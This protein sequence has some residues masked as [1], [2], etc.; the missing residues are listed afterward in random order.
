VYFQFDNGVYL[1]KLR[2][3]TLTFPTNILLEFYVT[4]HCCALTETIL[5]R[6][7]TRVWYQQ[8]ALSGPAWSPLLHLIKLPSIRIQTLCCHQSNVFLYAKPVPLLKTYTVTPTATLLA[9]MSG[10]ESFTG[11]CKESKTGKTKRLFVWVTLGKQRKSRLRQ[12]KQEIHVRRIIRRP[13]LWN[14]T[15]FASDENT[16]ILTLHG[17]PCSW[18]AFSDTA[19][20]IKAKEIKLLR[21]KSQNK[22]LNSALFLL[23][24]H[25]IKLKTL[26]QFRQS[27]K[28]TRSFNNRYGDNK[29]RNN[30]M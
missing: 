26:K 3:A 20:A 9:E 12:K 14:S 4:E 19:E 6:G 16:T 25:A 1:Q 18:H 21:N 15:A 7:I 2:H 10:H 22:N 17:S 13:I 24:S 8:L 5:Q 28:T 11:K 23:T 27:T 29:T 30:K